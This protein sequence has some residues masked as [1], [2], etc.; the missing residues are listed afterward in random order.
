MDLHA[1]LPETMGITNL[2]RTTPV[3]L[4]GRLHWPPRQAAGTPADAAGETST[5]TTKMAVFDTLSGTFHLM[6]GPPTATADQTKVFDM[7]GRLVA[8]DFGDE[9]HVQWRTQRVA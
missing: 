3:A 6:A 2:L 7:E 4:E 9:E 1:D 8:A 5:S